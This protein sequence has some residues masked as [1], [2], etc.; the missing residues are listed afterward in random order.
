MQVIYSEAHARESCR[1]VGSG[2]VNK[3]KLWTRAVLS[4]ARFPLPEGALPH[5][6]VYSLN[7]WAMELSLSCSGTRQSFVKSCPRRKGTRVWL[8]VFSGKGESSEGELQVPSVRREA[9]KRQGVQKYIKSDGKKGSKGIWVESQQ[10]SLWYTI[11]IIKYV[12]VHAQLCLTLYD[13]MDC[14][15]PCSSV[16]GI[17]QSRIA[18]KMLPFPT[19]GNRLNPGIKL[20][21][22]TSPM[23][24]ALAG[25][26]FTSSATC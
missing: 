26:F 16:H 24:P 4:Q 12:C 20:V 1:G 11:S 5:S 14:S 21:A 18:W 9:K 23:S 22:P 7:L 15:P 8:W 6:R 10:H 2:P 3:K 25:R 17:F 19:P 13:P